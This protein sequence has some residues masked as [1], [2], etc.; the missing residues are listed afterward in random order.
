MNILP[1]KVLENIYDYVTDIYVGHIK[2]FQQ[3]L[4]LL[5]VN[6]HWRRVGAPKLYNEVS[7]QFGNYANQNDKETKLQT[8]LELFTTR[9]QRNL[10]TKLII[11]ERTG[12]LGSAL[13][14]LL[15][16]MDID[17]I[18][19]PTTYRVGEEDLD[20]P[21]HYYVGK[22]YEDL[23]GEQLEIMEGVVERFGKKFQNIRNLDIYIPTHS[24]LTAQFASSLIST[25][26]GALTSLSCKIRAT[27]DIE[28]F[29][30]HLTKLR[31]RCS[32]YAM[33]LLMPK[34]NSQVL[35]YL[36]LTNVYD[37][38]S[39][40]KL[41]GNPRV[42]F[43]ALRYLR[44]CGGCNE[45]E[46]Q[47]RKQMVKE[48]GYQWSIPSLMELPQFPELKSVT[49]YRGVT[50]KWRFWPIKIST[51]LEKL[52]IYVQAEEVNHLAAL[53]ISKV[54]RLNMVVYAEQG[55]SLRELRRTVDG[56]AKRSEGE[57]WVEYIE[58]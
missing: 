38:F 1:P 16:A 43:P 34:V 57:C 23:D 30:P 20:D 39:W 22:Y 54:G 17:D 24:K 26:S 19:V 8:N 52:S 35:E 28:E 13:D 41:A 51:E 36:E 4:P 49:V 47:R 18:G 9:W 14:H 27:L 12:S 21:I 40:Y 48:Q 44:I 45:T 5:A 11:H 10:V 3:K 58:F 50:N 46:T 25:F 7:I 33:P 32:K 53:P 31:Y 42:E 56:F 37:D 29:P 55:A 2:N 6:R 15:G